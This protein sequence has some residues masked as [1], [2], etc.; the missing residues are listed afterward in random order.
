MNHNQELEKIL[1][2]AL[3][4]YRDAEPLSGL[5]DRVMRRIQEQKAIR[6]PRGLRWAIALGCAAAIAFAMWLGL[7]RRPPQTTAPSARANPESVQP[8]PVQ[9][10]SVAVADTGAN[11]SHRPKPARQTA[12]AMAPPEQPTHVMP[13]VFP[14][15]TPLT[16]E[17]RAFVAALQRDPVAMPT[18]SD[19]D[20]AITIAEIEI[21]PLSVGGETSGDNQ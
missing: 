15:P 4:E 5:E 16:A 21:K 7:E 19:A 3:S 1:D 11:A 14:S 2:Q 20:T 17:E 10:P 18:A 9:V 12:S 6:Q 8:A 13:A